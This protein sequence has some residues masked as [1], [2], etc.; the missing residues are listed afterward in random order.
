[1][2]LFSI[3]V[4]AL[5]GG[6]M[7][8]PG[9][10]HL[11]PAALL[12]LLLLAVSVP[13]LLRSWRL[14]LVCFLAWLV[15]EDLVRKLAGNDLTVYFVKDAFYVV[16]LAAVVL[17][18][19]TRGA[20]RAATGRARVPLYLLLGWALV[21]SVPTGLLDWKLP[22]AGLR[23][24]FLYAPL[25]VVGFMLTRDRV[26]LR[27]VML[28]LTLV[29]GLSSAVGI[30][31]AVLGPAFLAPALPTPDLVL[32]QVR[33]AQGPLGVY[34]P[35]GTFVDPARY[36]SMALA[37][38]AICLISLP[39]FRGFTRLVV[40]A[41]LATCAA[42]VWVSG[43]R[44]YFLGGAA[45]V[46]LA[47]LA[48]A[49]MRSRRNRGGG[50]SAGNRG[51]LVA[52]AAG[53]TVLALAI[54]AALSLYDSRLAWY[55][56]TL[57]PRSSLN[58]WARVGSYTDD[59]IRGLDLGGYV[60]QGTGHESLGKQYLLGSSDPSSTLYLVEGGYASVLVEWGLV[61]LILWLAWSLT[62]LRRAWVVGRAREGPLMAGSLVL[63][64][65][66]VFMLFVAFFLGYQ[67]FQNYI[68]NAYFWLFSGLIF[69]GAAVIGD[70]SA[71]SP[72]PATVR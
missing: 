4:G 32:D 59:I 61:G 22:V 65:W 3:G 20:W 45:F 15:M 52:A 64:G 66:T 28:V 14:S 30:V 33:G 29:G 38:L 55:G 54:S 56:S 39:A 47:L 7:L 67:T 48:G 40:S 60:G 46:I 19:R 57:D 8:L 2:A 53:A 1:M 69:G 70:A 26:G 17:D 35:T 5:V 13:V 37:G 12:A 16:L 58:E 23:L 44:L 25:V 10:L 6:W 72:E 21:M 71:T 34:R 68:A 42:G 11:P 41:C 36:D 18:P 63:L 49:R 50:G 24:D 9:W 43:G 27:K 62:W 31:Q 51:W